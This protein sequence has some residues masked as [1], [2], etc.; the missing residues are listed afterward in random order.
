MPARCISGLRPTGRG[1]GARLS[2][3]RAG[4]RLPTSAPFPP[5]EGRG[6]RPRRVVERLAPE[7]EQ[8]DE[9]AVEAPRLGEVDDDLDDLPVEEAEVGRASLEREPGERVQE[10]VEEARELL[11]QE[12]RLRGAEAAR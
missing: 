9:P 3:R 8:R 7:A 4:G 2:E 12:A 1:R 5:A 11:L 10:P 6:A